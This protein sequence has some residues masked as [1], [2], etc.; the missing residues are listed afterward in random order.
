VPGKC[1]E[2]AKRLVGAIFQG[3]DDGP[4]IHSLQGL[5]ARQRPCVAHMSW[6]SREP[7]EV[8]LYFAPLMGY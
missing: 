5:S 1:N 2:N 3:E 6:H 7:G 8:S 4:A